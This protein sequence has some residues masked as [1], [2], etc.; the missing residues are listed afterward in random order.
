VYIYYMSLSITGMDDKT[1]LTNVGKIQPS[2]SLYHQLKSIEADMTNNMT[3]GVDTLKKSPT[4]I[5]RFYDLEKLFYGNPDN[6]TKPEN[7]R[8]DKSWLGKLELTFYGE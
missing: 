3:G 7:N 5:S 2:E 8:P 4:L 6:Y 1:L